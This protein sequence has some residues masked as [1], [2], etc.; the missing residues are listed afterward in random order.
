MTTLERIALDVVRLENLMLTVAN[1]EIAG[2][3]LLLENEQGDPLTVATTLM[4]QLAAYEA[5]HSIKLSLQ[6]SIVHPTH[7]NNELLYTQVVAVFN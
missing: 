6:N 2:I 1:G 7:T 3:N 4:L 5:V